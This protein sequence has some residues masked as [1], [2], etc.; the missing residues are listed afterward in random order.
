MLI[1]LRRRFG[2]FISSFILDMAV[3]LS[4]GCHHMV[5]F[6]GALVDSL[7]LTMY[8]EYDVDSS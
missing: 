8:S 7:A 6:G 4:S 3:K 5:M 2:Q 1:L